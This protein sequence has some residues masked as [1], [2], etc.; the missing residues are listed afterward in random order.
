MYKAYFF[1]AGGIFPN[2]P[3][4]LNIK[5][6]I[7]SMIMIILFLYCPTFTNT[8]IKYITLFM[9]FVVSYVAMAWYDYIFDCRIAPLKKGYASLQQYI[10]PDAHVPEKQLEDKDT[11]QDINL[12]KLMIYLFHILMVVP[13]LLYIVYYKKKVHPSTYPIVAALTA[14]TFAY[15]GYKMIAFAIE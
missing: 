4:Q 15:H 2:K 13:L 5:C 8:W 11:S 6:I 10:K 7:F 12:H 1:M 14:F 3:F 9:I